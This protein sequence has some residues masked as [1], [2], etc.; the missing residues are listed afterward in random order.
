MFRFCS[1]LFGESHGVHA[2]H[3]QSSRA[4]QTVNIQQV[5]VWRE[6][7]FQDADVQGGRWRRRG[8]GWVVLAGGFDQLAKPIPVRR[9][10]DRHP[11]GVDSRALRHQVSVPKKNWLAYAYT[12]NIKTSV[13]TILTL[14]L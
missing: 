11:V 7:N 14:N 1:R 3:V 13:T 12:Q 2:D 5:R 8:R 6:G 10:V 9:R 4:I